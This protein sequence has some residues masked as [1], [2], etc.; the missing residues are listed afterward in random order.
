MDYIDP[1]LFVFAA[2]SMI[3]AYL[4][5]ALRNSFPSES[6]VNRTRACTVSKSHQP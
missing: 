1:M 3:Y 5:S 2:I 4:L 6:P